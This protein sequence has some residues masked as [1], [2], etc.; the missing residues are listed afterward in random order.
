MYD[1]TVLR[2]QQGLATQLEVTDARLGALQART[3]LAQAIA[4]FYLA[5]AGVARSL[6]TPLAPAP[7]TTTTPATTPARTP[8]TTTPPQTTPAT[9]TPPVAPPA[10]TPAAPRAP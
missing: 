4:A 6:G 8:T 1:L 10:S 9:T 3:N 7:T 2:Y 5:D